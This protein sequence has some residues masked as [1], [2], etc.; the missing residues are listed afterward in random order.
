[1]STFKPG[2]TLEAFVVIL[3]MG[4]SALAPSQMRGA[5]H[6]SRSNEANETL[7][8]ST[9][10]NDH[11]SGTL[12]NPNF[13]KTD[14]PFATL[15]RARDV[16]RIK[17]AVHKRTG[18][19]VIVR[20][21]VYKLDETF[22]LGPED[23]GTDSDPLLFKAYPHEH[24]VLSGTRV[25]SNFKPYKGRILK[26]DLKE[27][28]LALSGIRQLFADGKRQTIA[29]FPNADQSDPIRHGFLYVEDSDEEVSKLKFKYS[30][31]SVHTWSTPNDA[32]IVIYPGPNYWNNTIAISK[33]DRDHKTITLAR[34]ASY[35]IKSGNRFYFQNILEELD[36]P[37]EWYFD[38][39]TKILY[40]WPI[41]DAAMRSVSFPVLKTVVEIK[42]KKSLGEND[43]SPA[44]IR[45]EGFTI[46]GSKEDAVIVASAKNIVIVG[47]TILNAGGN[48]IVIE[49]GYGNTA[50]GNDIYEVGGAGIILSGGDR[51]TLTPGG[52]RAD[53]N[54]I[55]HTGIFKKSSSGIECS[56]AGNIVSHN[57]I[58]S[59]PR[60]GILFDGNDHIIEYNHVHHVNQETQDSGI[61]CSCARDWTKRGNILR[62]NYVHDSGGYGW[63]SA[64]KQWQ[65]PLD[66]WG[67][68]LDDWSSGTEVY[69]NICV[70]TSKGGIFIHG[71][72][73]NFIENNIII[74]GGN[75]QMVYSS[76]PS[77]AQELSAMFA[78]IKEMNYTRYPLLS[79]IKDARNDATMSGNRFLHNII[80]YTGKNSMLYDIY[81]D[82][83][84]GS[85]ISDFNV[86]WHA[87]LPLLIPYMRTP[88]DL[89][90][91]KWR[92]SGLDR[93][94][95]VAD[96]LFHNV[97]S[98]G[99]QL[100]HASP[101]LR[102][103][104]K[105][106]PFDQIGLYQDPMRA[107]W[108]VKHQ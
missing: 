3:I 20:G 54:Y 66:T 91:I 49:D 35:P 74:N 11:W 82:L 17:N 72:K 42:G 28:P 4:L 43:E 108:P 26:S 1:M 92:D 21:G 60:I 7:Y 56:G 104:F 69:G 62:F 52:N 85:T 10:G 58:H 12:K 23:S 29:R 27:V 34:E 32:E 2:F 80:Y 89:Q 57:L 16:I 31:G 41:N 107:S 96:P 53:N 39:R 44:D 77:T 46:E 61:I 30:E 9:A 98:G 103:G 70:D 19:T 100:S 25:I 33:I 15:K 84:P 48:G 55:H 47:C 37:G 87:G 14:G 79:M 51:K 102:M 59:T 105:P 40:F 73:D 8:V 86:I 64:V 65:S 97:S 36:S 38:H 68:Y 76:I 22:T 78:K 75:G 24:P 67:I 63:N 6:I 88:D 5:S 81:G 93:N 18:F 71:G 83:D 45:F 106:I 95:V 94:S 99:F 101:A 50:F 13:K 90:W